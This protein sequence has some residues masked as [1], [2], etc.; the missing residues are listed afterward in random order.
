MDI[1]AHWQP[2]DVPSSEAGLW[3]WPETD[4]SPH[5][6]DM[7]GPVNVGF[8]AISLVPSQPVSLAGFG[9]LYRRFTP[10]YFWN[11]GRGSSLCL[12]YKNVDTA[13]EPRIKAVVWQ[14]GNTAS[15]TFALL[16]IDV[17]A[18]TSDVTQRV[19]LA[20]QKAFPMQ[21][22]DQTHV[23]V[24][25]SHTHSGPAGLSL[26][27]VWSVIGCD[28]YMPTFYQDFEHAVVTAVGSA[29]HNAQE[30]QRF[31]TRSGEAP[32]LNASRVK[33]MAVDSHFT[34]WEFQTDTTSTAVGQS[35]EPVCLQSYS[36]HPTFFGP[37]TLT[38]SGDVVGHMENTLRQQNAKQCVFLNATGGNAVAV[39]PAAGSP[40]Q[41]ANTYAGQWSQWVF[42]D[43]LFPE[44]V[45]K[46]RFVW[47]SQII[48]IPQEPGLPFKACGVNA[49]K[50]F[51][52]LGFLKD[53]P[54]RTKIAFAIWGDQ[55]VL[56]F[57][58]EPL[59]ST[60]QLF[61]QTFDGDLLSQLGVS[62]FSFI[63]LANDY[64]SYVIT[65]PYDQMVS[66]ESCSS[67]Y[68]PDLSTTLVNGYHDLISSLLN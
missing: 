66:L 8:A 48:A 14:E 5:V 12:P 42:Q 20:L 40:A 6:V 54:R 7:N 37:E 18:I 67:L 23:H 57:P 43:G 31:M 10:P 47:G 1:N 16:S 35:R 17:V 44:V 39:L 51:L 4:M 28:V 24:V 59:M 11:M 21:N 13:A 29:L 15:V 68:G 56:F 30:V 53:L 58:G 41:S 27:P 25:A 50:P 34:H 3:Q 65:R 60:K 61:A 62:N 45:Q 2:L 19:V 55:L 26:H 32:A 33:G 46:Q 9:G 63:S 22:W 38:L 52:N 36:L 64:L 49:L